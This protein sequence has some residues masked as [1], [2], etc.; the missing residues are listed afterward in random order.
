[1]FALF[2]CESFANSCVYGTLSRGGA[3][4]RD[5]R[6]VKWCQFLSDAAFP[7]GL[8]TL[9]RL[10]LPQSHREPPLI[11]YSPSLGL[12]LPEFSS[13]LPP[14]SSSTL[15]ASHSDPYASVWG[16]VLSVSLTASCFTLPLK[17]WMTFPHFPAS[18]G[19]SFSRPM[20]LM[21]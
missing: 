1:M 3:I 20:K 6:R 12:F 13:P 11:I 7:L 10:H 19:W 17:K 18:N 9:Q 5:R 15:Y 4:K 16:R 21:L 8:E 2:A 14:P